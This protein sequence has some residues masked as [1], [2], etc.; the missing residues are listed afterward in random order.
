MRGGLELDIAL[1]KKAMPSALY[2]TFLPG[3]CVCSQRHACSPREL[4]GVCVRASTRPA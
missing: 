3:V 4:L 1:I 2:L